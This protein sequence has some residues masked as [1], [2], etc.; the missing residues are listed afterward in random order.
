MKSVRLNV[1]D[2]DQLV[3]KMYS[4]D[5]D[6]RYGAFLDVTSAFE[7]HLTEVGYCPEPRRFLI[8]AL[9]AAA[10][11]FVPSSLFKDYRW[12][13][14]FAGKTSHGEFEIKPLAGERFVQVIRSFCSIN[15]P[16]KEESFVL[17]ATHDAIEQ[18]TSALDRAQSGRRDSLH[19][20]LLIAVE[21]LGL[22]RRAMDA[23]SNWQ[24][25]ENAIDK[26]LISGAQ[27]AALHLAAQFRN[28]LKHGWGWD[29]KP[30]EL[31]D[32][33]QAICSLFGITGHHSK[34]TSKPA[35]IPNKQGRTPF[36]VIT[37]PDNFSRVYWEDIII[38]CAQLKGSASRET[39]K[40]LPESLFGISF[41]GPNGSIRPSDARW[42]VLLDGVRVWGNFPKRLPDSRTTLSVGPL[43]LAIELCYE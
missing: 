42:P 9:R 26:H 1:Q 23:K 2:W 32:C 38:G 36:V 18:L 40:A 8:T 28:S 16:C 3:R 43:Q 37:G 33:I 41:D 30:N 21:Y 34:A 35:A 4:S 19:R 31:L 11:G 7:Q 22:F 39:V 27:A 10:A 14:E 29:I 17:E 25:L 13:I 5:D 15:E 12:S 20:S 6:T 24:A